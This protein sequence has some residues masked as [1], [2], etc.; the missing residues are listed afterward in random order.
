MSVV[1]EA[2]YI[3]ATENALRTIEDGNYPILLVWT[4][5]DGVWVITAEGYPVPPEDI[6]NCKKIRIPQELFE[7]FPIKKNDNPSVKGQQAVKIVKSMFKRE[8]IPIEL[9]VKEVEEEEMQIE[10]IDMIVIKDIRIQT[11]CDYAAGKGGTGNLFLQIR[12]CNPY[13]YH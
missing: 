13:K 3:F 9:N 8:L 4:L 12:E 6:K 5:V 7:K 1:A 10:G 11:K 2:L